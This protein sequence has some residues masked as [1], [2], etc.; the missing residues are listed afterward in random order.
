MAENWFLKLRTVTQKLEEEV[1]L[2]E[3]ARP[4]SYLVES[5]SS[6]VWPW[7][8]QMMKKRLQT[9]HE[10]REIRAEVIGNLKSDRRGENE[11]RG[12]RGNAASAGAVR[13]QR[14]QVLAALG[15]FVGHLGEGAGKQ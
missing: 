6:R 10:E 13:S 1:A 9:S 3:E 15:R 2:A 14:G 11:K 4:T 12:E 8:V 5:D 7:R